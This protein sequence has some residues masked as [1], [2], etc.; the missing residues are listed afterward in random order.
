MATNGSCELENFTR[1]EH[2]A[3]KRT[4][5]GLAVKEGV[6]LSNILAVAMIVMTSMILNTFLNA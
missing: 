6:T 4:I 1:A 5:F 3:V 2:S